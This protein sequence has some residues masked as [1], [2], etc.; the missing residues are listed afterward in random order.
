MLANK[1]NVE[2]GESVCSQNISDVQCCPCVTEARQWCSALSKCRCMDSRTI[3][4]PKELL[5]SSCASTLTDFILNRDS[6]HFL[7][8]HL[9]E[10]YGLLVDEQIVPFD[11]PAFLKLDELQKCNRIIN[12]DFCVRV[13]F[14][15]SNNNFDHVVKTHYNIEPSNINT[16]S[17]SALL[18][19][20]EQTHI[21]ISTHLS[22]V[23]VQKNVNIV[24]KRNMKQ[25]S[26]INFI[27]KERI[28]ATEMRP[29]SDAEKTPQH[30]TYFSPHPNCNFATFDGKFC[31]GNDVLNLS[32]SSAPCD[33]RGGYSFVNSRLDSAF[34][35]QSV[36][37]VSKHSKYYNT[38]SLN[39]NKNERFKTR[40]GNSY[41]GSYT[42]TKVPLENFCKATV[43]VD[44]VGSDEFNNNNVDI[45]KN[46]DSGFSPSNMNDLSVFQEDIDRD[47]YRVPKTFYR[48]EKGLTVYRTKPFFRP[49]R[50]G[51]EGG[52]QT[53]AN[54]AFKN[55]SF[56]MKTLSLFDDN[57]SLSTP[58]RFEDAVRWSVGMKR[59][60]IQ[61]DKLK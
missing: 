4:G 17:V 50:V 18:L 30:T 48:D 45:P 12:K 19:S 23:C 52:Q 22:K 2:A 14:N 27:D 34:Y 38:L 15:E 36:F 58:H 47:Q 55:S 54:E 44:T 40:E 24:Q 10:V 11:P 43:G 35:S 25:M 9:S 42:P 32:F 33:D 1:R 41:F 31:A 59:A 51:Y 29:H 3:N 28:K 13:I 21:N 49:S 7:C 16:S 6:S 37:N 57:L 5:C 46:V 53:K 26:I 20:S 60:I 39:T 8:R 61:S 56:K